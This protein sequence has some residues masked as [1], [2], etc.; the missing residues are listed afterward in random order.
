MCREITFTKLRMT[1]LLRKN[2]PA[3][4]LGGFNALSILRQYHLVSDT[5]NKSFA[6]YY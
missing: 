6:T 5:P 4:S 3:K 2:L 1:F